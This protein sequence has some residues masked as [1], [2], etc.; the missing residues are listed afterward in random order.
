MALIDECTEE[1]KS[2]F[3]KVLTSLA[4][5]AAKEHETVNFDV[6]SCVKCLTDDGANKNFIFKFNVRVISIEDEGDTE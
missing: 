2:V 3:H 1:E 6:E 5:D 4:V